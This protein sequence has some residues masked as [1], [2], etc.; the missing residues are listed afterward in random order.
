MSAS[1]LQHVEDEAGEGEAE[2]HE[3]KDELGLRDFPPAR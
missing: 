1:H 3:V 2:D